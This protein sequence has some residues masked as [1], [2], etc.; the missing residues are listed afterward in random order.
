MTSSQERRKSQSH[1]IPRRFSAFA[2]DTPRIPFREADTSLESPRLPRLDLSD[3]SQRIRHR[4]PMR[5][6]APPD[7]H[8]SVRLTRSSSASCSMKCC[9]TAWRTSSTLALRRDAPAGSSMSRRSN[10]VS[11]S[12]GPAL[13][14]AAGHHRSPVLGHTPEFFEN[15]FGRSPAIARTSKSPQ[16]EVKPRVPRVKTGDVQDAHP[17]TDGL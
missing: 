15:A 13:A 6:R 9:S 1:P 3:T 14:L 12:D 2:A 4:S 16:Y 7:R 17:Q 10:R 11:G 5:N 8:Q